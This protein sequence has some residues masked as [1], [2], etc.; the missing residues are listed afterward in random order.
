MSQTGNKARLDKAF[1]LTIVII[2]LRPD[3]LRRKTMVN[4]RKNSKS[5]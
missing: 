3:Q 4:S 1:K 5:S 2:T